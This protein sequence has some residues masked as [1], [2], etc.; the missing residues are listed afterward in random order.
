MRFQLCWACVVSCVLL[1]SPASAGEGEED[2]LSLIRN[3]TEELTKT[4]TGTTANYVNGFGHKL[5]T[6]MMTDDEDKNVIISPTGIAGLL[7]MTLLGTV[8]RS[9]DELADTLGFS[10]D[11]RGNLKNHEEFGNLLRSLNG[12]GLSKTVYADVVLVDT[13]VKLRDVYRQFLRRVYDGEALSID[14]GDRNSAKATINKWVSEHTM[15]KISEFLKEPLPADTR[16]V[17]LSALYFASQWQTPFIPEF[18]NKMT[19]KKPGQDVAADLMLNLGEFNY[20][21][22]HDNGLQMIA[23]PYNDSVTTLY[24]L[25]PKYPKD[26][27]IKELLSKLDFEQ[28]DR[29]IDEMKVQKVVVRFPKMELQSSANLEGA[30]KR[31]GIE[32]IFRPKLANFALMIDTNM[33]ANKTENEILARIHDDDDV[34]LNRIINSLPNPDVHIDSIIHD[35]RITINEYGTEAVAATAGV[36]AKTAEQFYAD[37]PFYMFIRNENTKLVTFSAI[38]NDPTT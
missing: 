22:S 24:A 29:L 17:L 4:R 27:S 10:R 14:F 15:E 13:H 1:V 2:L 35:V 20:T 21:D 30:M 7:A 34:G 23:L 19:F 18:T 9:Y 8:G 25:K 16:A 32:T 31:I 28:I 38:I 11:V 37:S 3:I 26:T 36:L 33:V 5:I 12:N 6:Q